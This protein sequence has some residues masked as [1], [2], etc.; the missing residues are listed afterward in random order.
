MNY[1]NMIELGLESFSPQVDKNG[2]RSKMLLS[3]IHGAV[4]LGGTPLSAYNKFFHCQ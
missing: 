4:D 2:C 3:Q 1:N